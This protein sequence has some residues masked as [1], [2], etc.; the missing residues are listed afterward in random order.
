MSGPFERLR[1]Q[2]GP[3]QGGADGSG[4]AAPLGYQQPPM[5]AE[6]VF[7]MFA[8]MCWI[9]ARMCSL[10]PTTCQLFARMRSLFPAMCSIRGDDASALAGRMDRHLQL[11]A[12]HPGRETASHT[13]WEFL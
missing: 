4:G 9:F 8:A 11:V 6:A 7:T 10:F 12:R 5:G 13:L 3:G 2:R 1:D